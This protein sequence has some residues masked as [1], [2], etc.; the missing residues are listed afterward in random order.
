M[1]P[2]V[3]AN[4]KGRLKAHLRRAAAFCELELYVEGEKYECKP[5]KICNYMRGNGSR[6]YNCFCFLA[7]QDYEAALRIDP[8]NDKLKEDAGKLRTIIQSTDG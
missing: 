7:L 5:M 3:D 2:K 4:A 8:K 6:N 1:V